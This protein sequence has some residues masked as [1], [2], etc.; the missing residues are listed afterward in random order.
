MRIIHTYK[1]CNQCKR[2]LSIEEFSYMENKDTYMGTC[3]ECINIK[4][5][6][7]GKRKAKSIVKQSWLGSFI[8]LSNGEKILTNKIKEADRQRFIDEGFG[9]IFL[10]NDPKGKSV[11]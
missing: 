3:R 4:K 2:E 8:T 11:L 9:F 5:N 10:G 7:T 6:K 1:T